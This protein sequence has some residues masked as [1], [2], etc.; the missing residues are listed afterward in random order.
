MCTFHSASVFSLHPKPAT[1]T[2]SFSVNHF[3]A[4]IF[5][6]LFSP[7]FL[8]A[9]AYC[10]LPLII[11]HLNVNLVFVALLLIFCPSVVSLTSEK[12]VVLPISHFKINY[13]V[14]N[15]YVKGLPK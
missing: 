4:F 15:M 3:C 10:L 5:S 8:A 9:V 7:L 12:R 6:A 11:L 13:V 1:G 14:E 2:F